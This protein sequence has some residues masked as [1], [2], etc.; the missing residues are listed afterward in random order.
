MA[1][2]RPGTNRACVV[3]G[4]AST[5]LSPSA[6]VRPKRTTPVEATMRAVVAWR[7]SSCGTSSRIGPGCAMMSSGVRGVIS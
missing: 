7:L 6:G 3:T 2:A 1:G 4:P 5:T